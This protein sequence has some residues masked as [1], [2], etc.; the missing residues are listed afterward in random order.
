MKK[1]TPPAT[2]D[3]YL[4]TFPPSVRKILKQVRVTIR[5]AAPAAEEKISYRMP[6]YTLHGA[7]IYFAAFQH[8][9]GIFPPVKGDEKLL[10]ALAPYRGPK[11]NLKFPL[12]KPI[13]YAL[14][15]RVVKRRVKEQ[16]DRRK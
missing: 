2:I 13:P 16:L 1:S 5:K 7:L 14:I 4:A 10:R 3:D 12:D 15:A 8:H 6:A 9:I 11:G